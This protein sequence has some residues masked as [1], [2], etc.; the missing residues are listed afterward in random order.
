MKNLNH[1]EDN[2]AG[3]YNFV[4]TYDTLLFVVKSHIMMRRGDVFIFE[5]VL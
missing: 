1:R 3:Q 5:R 4:K 2:K